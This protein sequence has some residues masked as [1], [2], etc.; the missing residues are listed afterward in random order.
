VEFKL[1]IDEYWDVPGSTLIA[2]LSGQ[3]NP[4]SRETKMLMLEREFTGFGSSASKG[5][6]NARRPPGSAMVDPSQY[7][8]P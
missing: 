3:L 1:S 8:P 2:E 6:E 4:L 5:V 7:P